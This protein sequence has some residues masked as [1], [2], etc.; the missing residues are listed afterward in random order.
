MGKKMVVSACLLQTEASSV[1]L[2]SWS[3]CEAMDH[4]RTCWHRTSEVR[5]WNGCHVGE[6]CGFPLNPEGEWKSLKNTQTPGL[7]WWP[8]CEGPGW[9]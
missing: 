7:T 3:L 1:S 9:C 4:V 2:L 6:P 5:E 8:R